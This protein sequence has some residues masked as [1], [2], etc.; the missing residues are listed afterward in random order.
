MPVSAT[1]LAIVGFLLGGPLLLGLIFAIYLLI[2]SRRPGQQLP[3]DSKSDPLHILDQRYA[4]GEIDDD[5]YRRRR[6]I[7]TNSQSQH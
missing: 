1:E 3:E 2:R 4:S 7:L 5:E 6:T